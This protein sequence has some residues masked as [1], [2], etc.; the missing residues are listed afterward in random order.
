MRNERQVPMGY[1]GNQLNV[2]GS[3]CSAAT[4]HVCRLTLTLILSAA[5]NLIFAR[6]DPLVWRLKI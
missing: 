3:A 1:V 4:A 6:W 2:I 5:S